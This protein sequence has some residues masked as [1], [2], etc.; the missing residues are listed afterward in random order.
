MNN[1]TD[2]SNEH[3]ARDTA[4]L[5]IFFVSFKKG[6]YYDTLVTRFS[7]FVIVPRVNVIKWLL[8]RT[9]ILDYVHRL[10]SGFENI[11]PIIVE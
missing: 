5:F 1:V 7:A 8:Y 2:A 11:T 4:R 3:L 9:A 6:R 10:A